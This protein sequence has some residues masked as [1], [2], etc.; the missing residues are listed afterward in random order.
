MDCNLKLDDRFMN[1][2]DYIFRQIAN[3]ERWSA[4]RNFFFESL[5]AS[6]FHWF[7]VEGLAA[8]RNELYLPGVSALLNGIEASLRLTIHQVTSTQGGTPALSPYRVLSNPLLLSGQS[9]GLPVEA[10]AFPDEDDFCA[11]LAT[12]KSTRIDVEVVRLRNNICHGNVLEFVQ[13]TG[14][15]SFF[16]PYGLCNIS[17]V[18]LGVS[19]D[20]AKALGDFRRDRGLLHYGPTPPIPSTPLLRT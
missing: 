13:G 16:T 8:L 18:L 20:W 19:F 3:S 12:S 11:K 5:S 17:A 4:E 7:F 2:A 9:L 1:H 14:D 15:N 10:L 6:E